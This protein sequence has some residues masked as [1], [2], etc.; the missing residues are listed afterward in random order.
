MKVEFA[1]YGDKKGAHALKISSFQASVVEKTLQITDL[2]WGLPDSLGS[3]PMYRARAIDDYFVLTKTIRDT[4]ASRPGMAATTAA[5]FPL[6][7]VIQ[8]PSFRSLLDLLPDP[9]V[10]PVQYSGLDFPLPGSSNS[11]TKV[12]LSG[13]LIES[14][15]DNSDRPVVWAGMDNFTE[16]VAEL[17][18]LIPPSIRRK[19]GFAFVCDPSVGNKDGYS[20]LYCPIAL[21]S[22]WTIKLVTEGPLRSGALDPTT[23]LYFLNPSVRFQINQSMDELGISINGF[24]E[25]RRACAC[26]NTLQN[27]ESSTN[28]EATKLLRNL[29]VLSPQSKL[30]ID[31]RTRV[32]N[33]ICSRIKSGSLD[34]M[35]LVRNIDFAQL[36]ASK[37]AK[38]AF[39]EG[40][41]VCLED[42]SSNIGTLAE[43]VLEAVYHSDRDWAEGTISGFAKY[44]NVCSDVVAGRVWNLFSESPDLA[45]EAATLMPNIKQHDHVLAVTAPNNVTNDLGIQLCNIAKKQRLPE[46]HAVGLAAHSSI[47]NAV[48]ELQNSWSPSELRKSLKRLRA[49]V[50][51]DK[52]LQ[53]VGQIENEQLSAVAAECCAENP[54][55]LPIHFDANS[56][57][58]RRVICDIITLSPANPDSLNLIE[59]A[60]EDSIQ[61]LLTD[62]LDPAYQRALSKTRFSNII[63]A[64][65]R[66]KLWDKMDPVA[67]PGFLKSTATAM[68]DR[69]H[70]GEIRADEVEPPLLGAIV[71]PDF[72]NRL[73]PSEGER[74]LNKVVN[75]FDTLN[76]LGEQD[77]ESWRSTYLARNQPVSNIDAIILGKF[78]RDRHWEGVAS[79]LAN[80]V[81][82]YRRQDLRPAV[83]QFPDLLNWIQ[84]YQFGGIAVRVSPDEWWHEVETTLTG[85]YS[86]GPRT[87]GIWERASGN[88]ADLVSEGTATNQWRQCLHGL[89]NGSQSGELTI[90]SLLKASLSDYRNNTHLR[91]LDETIP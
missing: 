31:A 4:N 1:A 55:L 35:K 59:V 15:L 3:S 18:S 32:V 83:S 61:L 71:H 2:A 17:W 45:V 39:F 85:L 79:S 70:E 77:F 22:K 20:V 86:N 37:M 90:K 87:S 27:L 33:E 40:I 23:E 67:N 12:Q 36:E 76:Q 60:I 58:W 41:Q 68:I 42:S 69:I 43:L 30:G 49:R 52:F 25:L 72:R 38:S 66:P 73:L 57:A 26:H 74:A 14:L 28:L 64:K 47:R 5:F 16:A 46:L 80:D 10:T 29:G 11:D 54:Q 21:A 19:L 63:D 53:T 34:A 88:P 91:M 51:I 89:R 78:V 50:D 56:S 75:A 84:R 8:V 24:P 62:E 48:Q 81:N 82:W 13:M 9:S 6:D 44:S 65:N 7:E